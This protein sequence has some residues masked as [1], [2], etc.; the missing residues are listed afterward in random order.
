MQQNIFKHV[1]FVIINMT[2]NETHKAKLNT[3]EKK[4]IYVILV[5]CLC[6]AVYDRWKNMAAHYLS[7]KFLSVTRSALKAPTK[8]RWRLSSK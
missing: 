7:D 1:S 8:V 5:V 3:Q 2:Q 6:N 4:N